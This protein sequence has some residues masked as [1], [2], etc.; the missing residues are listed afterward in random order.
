MKNLELVSK[1]D[2]KQKTE[3]QIGDV[4]IG[5]DF[6]VIAGPCGVESKDQI[7]EAAKAVKAAGRICFAEGHISQE[8]HLILFKG[9]DE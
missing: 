9:L 4:K 6:L 3:I 1:S 8:H 7:L 2:K 5:K